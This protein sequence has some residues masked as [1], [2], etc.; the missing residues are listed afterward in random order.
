M[1]KT[2]PPSSIICTHL[3]INLTANG[4]ITGMRGVGRSATKLLH[5]KT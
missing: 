1:G 4:C 3:S 2:I 5:K